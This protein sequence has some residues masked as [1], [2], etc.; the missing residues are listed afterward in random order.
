MVDYAGKKLKVVDYETGEVASVEFFV[1]VLACSGYTFAI[2]SKSQQSPDFLGCLGACLD[3]I[4]GV[5]AAIVTD[6]L[7]PAVNK[8]SKYDRGRPVPRL[9]LAW[10]I[11]PSITT[12]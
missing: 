10:L 8:A 5:P 9:I 2:A 6:N 11:L 4:G 12:Q 1:G 3:D 7:K